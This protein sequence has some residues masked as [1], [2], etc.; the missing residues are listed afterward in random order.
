M[1]V[2]NNAFDKGITHTQTS[3]SLKRYLDGLYLRERKANNIR[4]YGDKVFLFAGET[5]ITV[6]RLP[7][8]YKKTCDRIR[9]K[10]ENRT[11]A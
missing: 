3:G 5:L 4:I 9:E 10:A 1:K 2:T 8:K 6:L 7:Q 11:N